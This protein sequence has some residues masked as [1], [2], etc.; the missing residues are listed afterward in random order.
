[1][2][3]R[4]IDNSNG[5]EAVVAAATP[6]KSKIV[7]LDGMTHASNGHFFDEPTILCCGSS[8]AMTSSFD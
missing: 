5:G 2:R 8:D 1:M 6:K 4:E 3:W 7:V